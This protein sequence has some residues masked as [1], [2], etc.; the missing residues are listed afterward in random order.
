MKTVIKISFILALF[1]LMLMSIRVSA[2]EQHEPQERPSCR[3]CGMWIDEYQKSAAELVYKDGHKESTC[4]V[5]CM[6]REVEDAG[7]MSAFQSVKVHDWVSGELVDA[8]TATYVLGSKIIPDMVPNYIAFAKREEAEAFAAKEGGEVIDFTIAYDDVSPVGT[9]APFRIRTAVT[10]GKG[11]FSAGIV[12]GYTQK[13]QVKNGDS[14]IDPSQFINANKAQPKAPNESQMMQQAIT[15][16]Y[17][18]TDNLALFMNLPWFEKRQ[19]TF[20]RNPLAGGAVE[21][22]IA[23]DDGFGDIT[24]EGR[25]NFWRSTRWDQFASVLLG[26]SL[27]TGEFDGARD[28]LVNPLAK[29]NLITKSP[30]LQIG[31]DTPTFTGG[32]L[33]SQRWK[34]FWLHTSALYTVNPENGDDYAYGDVATAGLALH[35]T[36]SYDLMFGVELDA[37]YTEKNE[38]RGFKIGNTGGTVTNLAVVSD[39]RFLNAF[40]G[41]FKLR[42]SIGL[43]IYEDL[44][45]RDVKNAMGMPFTQ[46]QL[47]EGFFG[48]LSVIWTFRSAPDY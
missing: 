33:Y 11:N 40:G 13:D 20:E 32:L 22:K 46:V 35:Y 38:D 10:P 34:D 12:Y 30:G 28:P 26:T 27:P 21:E 31:K 15:L 42:G 36:P 39:W 17:S 37:S 16:N 8:Q 44:N 7:G 19:G 9:T 1:L 48:N 24:L 14:G 45:A 23:E 5:A 25:Y 4:G 2:H 29:T 47:G 6:L 41:N 18:P 43:P 3:V